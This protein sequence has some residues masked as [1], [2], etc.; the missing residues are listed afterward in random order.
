MH[1]FRQDLVG[2]P[3]GDGPFLGRTFQICLFCRDASRGAAAAPVGRCS[4][5]PH[6][7]QCRRC[8]PLP[9]FSPSP[10]LPEE[11]EGPGLVS[12][13]SD[14]VCPW[15][16]PPPWPQ[17]ALCGSRSRQLG[18]PIWCPCFGGDSAGNTT[19]QKGPRR[20]LHLSKRAARKSRVLHRRRRRRRGGQQHQQRQPLA[21]HLN[22]SPLLFSL[23]PATG[24]ALGPRAADAAPAFQRAAALSDRFRQ[25]LKQHYTPER[26][27]AKCV[28]RGALPC[29]ALP[30]PSL[31]CRAA[32]FAPAGSATAGR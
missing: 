22:I 13:I 4:P 1:L 10:C 16:P 27:A 12:G 26:L 29:P 2:A 11:R 20:C 7:S 25:L 30:C 3:F 8:A 23:F 21:F 17:P 18:Q 6:P 5:S 24:P 15:A 14:R 32:S 19:P 9:H 31:P 28:L